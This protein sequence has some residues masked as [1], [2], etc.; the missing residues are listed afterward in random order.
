MEGADGLQRRA[1]A[2]ELGEE[3][4]DRAADLLVGVLDDLAVGGLSS[5]L[6]KLICS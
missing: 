4:L 6:R 3:V 2:L 5:L 1:G